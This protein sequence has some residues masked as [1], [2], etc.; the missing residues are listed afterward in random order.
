[1]ADSVTPDQSHSPARPVAVHCA[2]LTKI[3]GEGETQVHALRGVDFDIEA[4][5]ENIGVS[6]DLP[7]VV[8]KVLV[9]VGDQVTAGQPL[10]VLDDR[11]ARAEVTVQEGLSGSNPASCPKNH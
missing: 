10:F 6:T 7:G 9:K 2:E 3:Y 5:T 8:A 11:Q 4:S 1:M